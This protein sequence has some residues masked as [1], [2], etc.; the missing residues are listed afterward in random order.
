MF[1]PNYRAIF[2]LNFE[3]VECTVDNAFNLRDFLMYRYLISYF[4]LV[5]DILCCVQLGA[6]DELMIF[7]LT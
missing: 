4:I 3:Q 5:L 7:I 6:V 2:R 1:R